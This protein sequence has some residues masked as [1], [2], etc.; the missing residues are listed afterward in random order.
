M[1]DTAIATRR[2]LVPG[3]TCWTLSPQT[4]GGLLIDGRDYFRA[5]YRAASHARRYILLCGWQFD[6]NVSLLRGKDR[7]EAWTDPQLLPFLKV[8]LDRNPQLEVRILCWDYSPAYFFQREWFQD[9][10]FNW[11]TP[12]RLKFRF[13]DR[14]AFGASHHQKFVVI[15]GALGFVGSMD[16]CNE[17]WDHRKHPARSEERLEPFGED[18]YGPYHEVQAVMTGPVVSELVDLFRAR[19][20]SSGGGDLALPE[21]AEQWTGPVGWSVR[22]PA[23]EVGLSR[24]VAQT[25]MPEQPSIREIRQLYIDAIGS[26]ERSIYIE[27]QYCGSTAVTEALLTRIRDR[28]RAPLN[29]VM[30]HPEKLH[31]FTESLSMGA[32]QGR[33][34]HRLARAALRSGHRLGVYYCTSADDEGRQACRYIHSKVLIVDDRFLTVGSANTNNRSMGLDTELNVSWEAHADD[35]EL[36][37][38]IRRARVSL[39]AEHGSLVK[40]SEVHSLYDDSR[41]V[42]TID[43][44]IGRKADGLRRHA[45]APTDEESS[46][47]VALDLDPERPA[48][49]EDLFER[50]APS[51]SEMLKAGFHRIRRR[52][53]RVGRRRRVSI[54]VDP[55]SSFSSRPALLWHAASRWS[56][57]LLIPALV[58]AVA[59]G[60]LWLLAILIREVWSLF[61]FGASAALIP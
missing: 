41:M 12:S 18:H 36:R 33:M 19:W 8:L 34:F 54:A 5:L 50:V 6:R 49:E 46:F 25:I 20:K 44:W 15:D 57:R 14:H 16:L 9:Y 42:E 61:P 59:L 29:I 4:S 32:A 58:L 27:N 47:P 1:T 11:S 51:R 2:I 38:A 10:R 26:A 13:D 39:Q 55:P 43:G 56:R 37:R 31:S 23:R 24:T 60:L 21:A 17:R 52:V 48:I 45:L 53:R 28:D 35:D 22:I 3:R 7:S 40:R 30:I